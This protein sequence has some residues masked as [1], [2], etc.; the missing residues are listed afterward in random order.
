MNNKIGQ[1]YLH[2]IIGPMMSGKT[3]LLRSHLYKWQIAGRRVSYV[4]ITIDERSNNKNI[5]K[6]GSASTHNLQLANYP[7]YSEQKITSFEELDTNYDVFGFD[8]IQFYSSGFIQEICT[9]VNYLGK[10]VICSGLK[11]DFRGQ[12][13]GF[14]MDLI[15]QADE[16]SNLHAIC[17]YC[18]HQ[19][20][21]GTA[22][23]PAIFTRRL[24][25][26]QDLIIP[27]G[28]GEYVAVCRFHYFMEKLPELN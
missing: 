13:F 7:L 1:G 16:V 8:E 28:T 25:K 2:V 22:L 14:V 26:S 3:T 18:H 20:K 27:G 6:V 10:I 11:A 21:D 24:N 17:P 4:N 15:A 19:N 23:H 5:K 9:M 12:K